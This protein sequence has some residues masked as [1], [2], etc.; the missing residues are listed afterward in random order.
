MK[1]DKKISIIVPVYNAERFLKRCVDSILNQT[2]G[3]FELILINDG[4]TDSSGHICNEYSAKDK[5]VL[6]INQKN[7]GAATA[8]SAGLDKCS[9]DFIGFV[10]SDDWMHP[11]MLEIMMG[12]ALKENLDIVEC[13]IIETKNDQVEFP[14]INTYN[15]RIENYLEAI[16]RIIK[17]TQ[18]SNW[19]RIYSRSVIG[20]YRYTLNKTSEDVFLTIDIVKKVDKLAYIDAKLYYYYYNESGTTHSAYS[21]DKLDSV[22]AGLYVQKTINENEKDSELLMITQKHILGKLLMHY[23]KLNYNAEVDPSYHYRNK[24]KGL[25]QKNYFKDK[26]HHIYL[27]LANY[28]SIKQFEKLLKLNQLR[29]RVFKNSDLR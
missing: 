14:E 5:R 26:G 28:L 4:S 19:R 17:N 2:Y 1:T 11:K 9:G 6:V 8:R 13:D 21:I 22:E 27:K 15:Y 20:N 18:F 12:V 10:D 24:I 29:H 23:K 7:Q 3:N 16:K 25:I